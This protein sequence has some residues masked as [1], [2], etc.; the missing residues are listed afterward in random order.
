MGG[1]G[2]LGAVSQFLAW[3]KKLFIPRVNQAQVKCVLG[4]LWLFSKL[5][6]NLLTE[7]NETGEEAFM[8]DIEGL[9]TGQKES[10]YFGI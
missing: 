1:T 6:T 5:P 7:G 9:V 8:G 2:K 4:V 3:N 10:P